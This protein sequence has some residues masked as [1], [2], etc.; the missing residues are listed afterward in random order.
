[1]RARGRGATSMLKLVPCNPLM[2]LR[3]LGPAGMDV[4]LQGKKGLSIG[5]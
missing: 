4:D 2:M 3:V 1:M 5:C